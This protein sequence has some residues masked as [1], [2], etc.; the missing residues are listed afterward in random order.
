MSLDQLTTTIIDIDGTVSMYCTRTVN[1]EDV[2]RNGLSFLVFNPVYSDPGEDI[3][4]ITQ[5]L[6]L[7]YF[8]VPYLYYVDNLLDQIQIITPDLQAASVREY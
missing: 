6:P 2:I 7:P 3:Q 1:G 5:S 8:K 4:V